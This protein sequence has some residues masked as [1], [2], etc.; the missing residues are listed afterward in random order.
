MKPNKLA[1][2]F[3]ILFFFA[4]SMFIRSW[5]P[6]LHSSWPSLFA[7][8]LVSV[9]VAPHFLRSRWFVVI[10]IYSLIIIINW[11]SGDNFFDTPMDVANEFANLFLFSSF[12][13]YCYK[14]KDEKCIRVTLYIMLALVGIAAIGSFI[15]NQINPAIVREQATFVETGNEDMIFGYYRMG[16]SNYLLP[17]GV[18]AIIPPL[19]LIVKRTERKKWLRFVAA[20][21]LAFTLLLVYLGGSTTVLLLSLLAL[22]SFLIKDTGSNRRYITLVIIMTLI[23]LPIMIV[24]ELLTGIIGVFSSETAETYATHFQDLVDY[25]SA[26]E[27]GNTSLRMELYLHDI[28]EFS[29]NPILGTNNPMTDH[30]VLLDRLGALG[31]LGFIPFI[32]I[33]VSF[34]KFVNRYLDKSEIGYFNVTVFVAIMMLLIKGIED[35]EVWLMLFAVV[36]LLFYVSH[37]LKYNK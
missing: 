12:C 15:V 28:N 2:L 4:T 7:A 31:F 20:L 36:P 25:S 10:M 18:P 24:P 26:G 34:V 23:F 11:M 13:F 17:H 22:S 29:S 35:K 5:V 6:A 30:S 32:A 3:P 21:F 37:Q 9:Y 14:T 19:V 16:L 8:C 1:I 27:V 33:I